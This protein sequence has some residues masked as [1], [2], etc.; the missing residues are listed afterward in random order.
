MNKSFVKCNAN[1][2][3][4]TLTPQAPLAL[5]AEVLHISKIFYVSPVDCSFF[6]SINDSPFLFF[7]G[8]SARRL[9]FSVRWVLDYLINLVLLPACLLFFP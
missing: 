1:D 7:A 5:K 2:F 9:G 3:P 8:W 6:Q 4:I